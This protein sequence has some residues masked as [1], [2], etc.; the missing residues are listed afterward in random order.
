MEREGGDSHSMRGIEAGHQGRG[1]CQSGGGLRV[2]ARGREGLTLVVSGELV[3]LP[4]TDVDTVLS[5]VGRATR[6]S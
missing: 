2:G 6:R 4:A 3:K 5:T 1:L